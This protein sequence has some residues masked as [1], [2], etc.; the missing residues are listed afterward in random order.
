M[1]PL[2]R[3]M[4]ASFQA[5]TMSVKLPV[6]ASTMKSSAF[7]G[8]MVSSAVSRDS[9]SCS[10]HGGRWWTLVPVPACGDLSSERF[11]LL[12][13]LPSLL[14]ASSSYDGWQANAHS[15]ALSL[16]NSSVTDTFPARSLPYAPRFQISKQVIL[17]SSRFSGNY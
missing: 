14:P 6:M 3:R 2:F 1:S 12:L 10:A 16:A 11:L 8:R 4:L 7:A 15:G 17:S 9:L 13:P 5:L